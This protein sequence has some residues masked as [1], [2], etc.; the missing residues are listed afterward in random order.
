MLDVAKPAIPFDTKQ[1]DRLMEEAGLD[2][3]TDGEFRD[4]LYMAMILP[5][6]LPPW[7]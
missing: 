1:L 6:S 2:V 7:P 4:E 3:F 5:G